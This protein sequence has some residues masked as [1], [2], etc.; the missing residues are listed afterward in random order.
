M[1]KYYPENNSYRRIPIDQTSLLG[2]ILVKTIYSYD[3]YL[4]EKPNTFV[5]IVF[6]V[7]FVI[8]KSE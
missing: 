5:L 6:F 8:P 4:G 7:N 3:E 1:V 2:L